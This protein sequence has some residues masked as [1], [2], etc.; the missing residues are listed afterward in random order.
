MLTMEPVAALA[1]R[2]AGPPWGG[3]R[4]RG[5]RVRVLEPPVDTLSAATEFLTHTLVMLQLRL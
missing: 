1:G 2:G 3:A 5:G 4:G